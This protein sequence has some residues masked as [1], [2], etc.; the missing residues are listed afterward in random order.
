MQYKALSAWEQ[1]DL[2]QKVINLS[3]RH[4]LIGALAC[5]LFFGWGFWVGKNDVKVSYEIA[6]EA[7][8]NKLAY[9]SVNDGS[10]LCVGN[11]GTVQ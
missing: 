2:Q 4:T 9:V 7:C 5:V 11:P 10:T 6:R 8:V 1:I 3:F